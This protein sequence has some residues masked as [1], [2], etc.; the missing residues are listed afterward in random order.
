MSLSAYTHILYHSDSVYRKRTSFGSNQ[1]WFWC[2]I[3]YIGGGIWRSIAPA[4]GKTKIA[5]PP[6]PSDREIFLFPPTGSGSRGK[7]LCNPYAGCHRLTYNSNSPPKGDFFP[8]STF[9]IH[10][11]R[12]SSESSVSAAERGI[13]ASKAMVTTKIGLRLQSTALGPF[14]CRCYDQSAALRPK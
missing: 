10:G 3:T 6:P 11:G 8:R 13:V 4:L 9:P 12:T 14:D 2:N 5:F 7:L 1:N